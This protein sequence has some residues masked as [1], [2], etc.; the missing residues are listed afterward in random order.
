[1]IVEES[2]F[3]TARM[4]E[5]RYLPRKKRKAKRSS[6][7]NNSNSPKN[8]QTKNK[9][10]HIKKNDRVVGSCLATR[11]GKN[12]LETPNRVESKLEQRKQTSEE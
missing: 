9:A 11:G 10:D 1:M 6:N 5:R 12:P 3:P 4:E 8:N 7:Q 2:K